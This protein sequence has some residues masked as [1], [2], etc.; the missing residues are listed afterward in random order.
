[1]AYNKKRPVYL[2]LFRIR[3]PV[4]G[5]VSIAHRV[6]G[7]LLVFAIPLFLYVLDLSL[8]D[9]DSFATC[10]ALLGGWLGR[11]VAFAALWLFV[12]HFFSGV[13]HLLLDLD[14]WIDRGQARATA[15]ATFAVA[16]ATTLVIAGW[17]WL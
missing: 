12:Q 5:V 1:M 16:L 11:L 7:V 13:R 3:L 4:T 8:H 15:W 14:I 9:A 6:S 10:R 17:V 2:N